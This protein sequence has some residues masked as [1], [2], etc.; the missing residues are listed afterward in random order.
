MTHNPQHA[1]SE[2]EAGWIGDTFVTRNHWHLAGRAIDL[3][4]LAIHHPEQYIT[5]WR[6]LRRLEILE[7]GTETGLGRRVRVDLFGWLP[8]IFRAEF[9]VTDV[10]YPHS[11]R[12]ELSG[13]IEGSGQGQ[14]RDGD[15]GCV[16][17]DLQMNVRIRRP[18]IRCIARCARP[19]IQWQH[20][21]VMK[22]LRHGLER[23]LAARGSM[24]APRWPNVADV[25]HAA[26][27]SNDFTSPPTYDRTTT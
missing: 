7:P 26:R 16:D 13:D 8:Y 23:W 4:D 10:D 25:G 6:G 5:L 9:L 2:F 1:R 17:I 3:A 12:V 14:L 20:W 24:N 27:R 22:R 11:F 19:F 15:D 18:L 21:L